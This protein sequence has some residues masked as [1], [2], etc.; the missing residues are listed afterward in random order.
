MGRVLVELYQR[1]G[2]VQA[3][4]AMD[5]AVEQGC[6]QAGVARSMADSLMAH[7]ESRYQEVTPA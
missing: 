3:A 2:L 6:Q 5:A 4:A 1:S 7:F